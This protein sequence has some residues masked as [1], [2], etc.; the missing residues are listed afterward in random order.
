MYNLLRDPMFGLSFK[1]SFPFVQAAGEL[2]T[3]VPNK[4]VVGG[5]EGLGNRT[6]AADPFSNFFLSTPSKVTPKQIDAIV[7]MALAGNLWNANQL[8][9]RMLRQWPEFQKCCH[10][11]RSAIADTDFK[12]HPYCVPGKEPTQSAK[13]RADLVQR[14]LDTFTPDR[15]SEEEG[16]H[17][18]VYDISDALMIG[19]SILELIWDENAK[20]DNGNPE[21]QIKSTAWVHP[22]HYT[23]R[24]D[25]SVGIAP[26]QVDN[27][28]SFPSQVRNIPLLNNPSKF[29]VAKAKTQ[30]GSCLGAGLAFVLMPIYAA[31]VYGWDFMLSFSQKYGNPFLDIAYQA[32]ISQAEIDKFEQL[33]K[34]AQNQSYC[35]HPSTGTINV[36]SAQNLGGSAHVQLRQMAD[37]FCQKVILG[38]TL[39]SSPPNTTGSYALGAVHQDIRAERIES[40]VGWVARILT[41]QLATSLLIENFGDASER[42]TVVADLSRPLSVQEQAQMLSAYSMSTIPIPKKEAYAKLMLTVP[43]PGDEVLIMGKPQILEESL[44]ATDQKQ[45]D[46]ELQ[47]EQQGEQMQMQ[48]QMMSQQPPAPT[49]KAGKGKPDKA[50]AK[51]STPPVSLIQASAADLEELEQLVSEAESAP[52]H[53]GE[54]NRL[55]A[56]LDSIQAFSTETIR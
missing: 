56:K 12:V 51:A 16:Q 28:L 49:G 31:V 13:D 33:A 24:S 45:K 55:K 23:F 26:D 21:K 30:S 27:T 46:F 15:F 1:S 3:T 17:G 7:T 35:V 52:H 41:E 42:P 37:E 34:L 22:R 54:I 5:I 25:G 2:P 18:M 44:T 47:L 40:A 11:F 4:K 14:A 32:G 9:R 8:Y 6:I 53:N 20:D 43:E 38:Q 19:I 50:K 10:E 39:T 48:A 29:I 36:T